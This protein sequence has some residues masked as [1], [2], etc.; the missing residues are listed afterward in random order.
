MTK[1]DLLIR[2]EALTALQKH[3]GWVLFAEHMK[4]LTAHEL[5]QM[6]AAKNNEELARH[7]TAYL[8]LLDLVNAPQ[9]TVAVLTHQLQ[10]M[11]E[12]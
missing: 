10:S 6:K 3:P 4:G 9:S 1:N 11:Q 2:A 5:T 12:K 7:T 8:L